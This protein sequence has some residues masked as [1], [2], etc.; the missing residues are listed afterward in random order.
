MIR[1]F[2][3]L[4]G[5][6]LL[7]SA[8]VTGCISHHVYGTEGTT[9]VAPGQDE[10]EIYT[11]HGCPD[12]II[13]LGNSVGP[14]EKHWNKYIVVFRIGEG[15]KILGTIHQSDRFSNIAYLIEDGTVVNGNHV[16]GGSGSTILMALQDAMHS[17]VRAGYGGDDGYAGSY[18]QQG[19][20]GSAI[21][22]EN[23]REM[24]R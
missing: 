10:G 16:A 22:K 5:A 1:K 20:R 19:R 3:L 4:L 14:A 9:V 15:H 24:L 23:N 12:Q 11:M 6:L 8:T 7:A 17:R 21:T 2:C 13:E 18:G